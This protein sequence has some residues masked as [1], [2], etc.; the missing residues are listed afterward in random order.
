MLEPEFLRVHGRLPILSPHA[1]ANHGHYDT[2]NKENACDDL[3][4]HLARFARRR[5]KEHYQECK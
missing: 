2:Q 1:G 4:P 3:E 5:V